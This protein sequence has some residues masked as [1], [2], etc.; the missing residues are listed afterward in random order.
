MHRNGSIDCWRSQ[1]GEVVFVV[2]LGHHHMGMESCLGALPLVAESCDPG[3]VISVIR[4]A[5]ILLMLRS[6]QLVPW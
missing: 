1:E 6:I 3:S 4:D 2:G 5:L